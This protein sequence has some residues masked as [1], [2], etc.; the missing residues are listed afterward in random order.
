[1]GNEL[2]PK[3]EGRKQVL[4]GDGVGLIYRRIFVLVSLQRQ[5]SAAQG[6]SVL[7]PGAHGRMLLL[8]QL[9]G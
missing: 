7:C 9:L 6:S 1:M 5:V 4:T 2:P 3:Q 8:V